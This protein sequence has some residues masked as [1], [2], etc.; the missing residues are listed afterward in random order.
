ML[1][2]LQVVPLS[3]TRLDAIHGVSHGNA[4]ICAR[5]IARHGSGIIDRLD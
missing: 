4:Q 2:T 5:H 1:V 3:W